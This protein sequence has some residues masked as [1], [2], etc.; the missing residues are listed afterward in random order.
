MS[1]SNICGTELAAVTSRQRII[2]DQDTIRS[3]YQLMARE[4]LSKHIRP[5]PA[6]FDELWSANGWARQPSDKVQL[7][8]CKIMRW[9]DSHIPEFVQE[10]QSSDD[11]ARYISS[12]PVAALDWNSD[13]WNGDIEN[14]STEE[15]AEMSRNETAEE[16][17]S[18]DKAT[19]ACSAMITGHTDLEHLDQVDLAMSDV[20]EELDHLEHQSNQQEDEHSHYEDEVVV[21]H[22]QQSDDH[23]STL[24]P[25]HNSNTSEQHQLTSRLSASPSDQHL[26]NQ[27]QEQHSIGARFYRQKSLPAEYVRQPVPLHRLSVQR[28]PAQSLLQASQPSPSTIQPDYRRS[29]RLLPDRTLQNDVT[30]LRPALTAS[31][32]YSHTSWPGVSASGNFEDARY[33][34]DHPELRS[35]QQ[36]HRTHQIHTSISSHQMEQNQHSAHD[37][38]RASHL[39]GQQLHHNQKS[40]TPLTQP[41]PMTPEIPGA[42][43][44]AASRLSENRTPRPAQNHYP[45]LPEGYSRDS[46]SRLIRPRRDD[47]QYTEAKPPPHVPSV[48]R[49]TSNHGHTYPPRSERALD[50][51]SSQQRVAIYARSAL[52]RAEMLSSRPEIDDRLTAIVLVLGSVLSVRRS[53]STQAEEVGRAEQEGYEQSEHD[54]Q[55]DD[56]THRRYHDHQTEEESF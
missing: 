17:L 20:E 7:V 55:V 3:F 43:S 24:R 34:F 53:Q 13:T 12:W 6:A 37:D 16:Y 25:Q 4:R 36:D 39:S 2:W 23:L 5:S 33:N 21:H 47:Q 51:R 44:R 1:T 31:S 45:Q 22:R 30:Q 8:V 49:A 15:N 50:G 35:V 29:Q 27:S 38:R 11:R 19:A 32:R 26:R 10:E 52:R 18:L 41:H 46:P 42:F 48:E 56:V 14:T 54:P 28:S 40:Q 9:L